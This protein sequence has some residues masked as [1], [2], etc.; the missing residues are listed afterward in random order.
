MRVV[1]YPSVARAFMSIAFFAGLGGCGGTAVS[2][3][4]GATSSSSGGGPITVGSSAGETIVPGGSTTNTPTPGSGDGGTASLCTTSG[5]CV[6]SCGNGQATTISGTVFDPRGR[7]P[8]YDVAVFVPSTTP[9][10]MPAGASC[11]S[12]SSLY[13]GSPIASALTD[14]TGH[15][16][17]VGVPSGAN[18]PLVVQIGKWRMQ[19]VLPSVSACTDNP[20]PDGT[21]H[22]PRNHAEGDLPNIAISTGGA[23]SLECLFRRIGIDDAEFGGGATGGGRVHIFQGSQESKAYPANTNPPAPASYAT[24][25]DR[26]ADLMPFDMVIL[27][28]E[29]AE[30]LRMQ[31]Q[32][33]LEYVDSGGR[34]FASHYHYAW[35]I[36]GP[37]ARYNVATWTRG[38][39]NNNVY[40]RVETTYQGQAFPKGQAM[41]DWLANVGALT[42]DELPILQARHNANI[43]PA[44]EPTSVPWIT[45]DD[46]SA[47]PGANMYFSFDTPILTS[48]QN[49]GDAGGQCGR[50][51]YSDMHVGGASGDY[52]T[53]VDDP[54]NAGTIPAGSIVPSGCADNALSPQEQALEFMIFDLSACLTPV[55]ST[56]A[57]P[58]A[59]G[60]SGGVR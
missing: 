54:N 10:A 12:C 49:S 34:V 47:T 14:A 25:W 27:S 20:V 38:S 48:A 22:L 19:F 50:V 29:G 40:A 35:F 59:T 9:S 56:P 18:I 31:Q 57:P 28:C 2:D 45:A 5:A 1:R 36:D 41:H 60:S 21:L 24:L 4:R 46:H 3:G 44:N 30:T 52:G 53:P 58:P 43:G 39:D 11:N 23:D 32:N 37:F 42:N 33:L 16:Q 6:S 17:L 7:E 26:V 15:F 51:V 8:L 55:T 13:T